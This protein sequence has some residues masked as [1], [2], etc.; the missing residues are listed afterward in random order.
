MVKTHSHKTN[1]THQIKKIIEP[2]ALFEYEKEFIEKIKEFKSKLCNKYFGETKTHYKLYKSGKN[3]VV[4]GISV[5][6]L[7][8][9]LVTSR[10]VSADSVATSVSSSTV[11]TETT[12]AS[13]SDTNSA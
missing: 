3:W 2:I 13:S 8:G 5:F 4:M 9:M 6:V 11:G 10:P 1:N 12:N 7:G